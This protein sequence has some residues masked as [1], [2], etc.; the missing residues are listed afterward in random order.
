MYSIIYIEL[1]KTKYIKKLLSIIDP[2]LINK[3]LLNQ[4]IYVIKNNIQKAN[5]SKK[6]ANYIEF[7]NSIQSRN[8][9]IDIDNLILVSIFKLVNYKYIP[10]NLVDVIKY[11]IDINLEI[12]TEVY[13]ILKKLFID[14]N[15]TNLEYFWTIIDK[16]N[17]KKT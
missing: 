7:L 17:Y 13:K 15:Y 6:I 16:N 11:R 9:I 10:D 5:L 1:P 14:I 12:N 3:D 8:S 2:D 4:S